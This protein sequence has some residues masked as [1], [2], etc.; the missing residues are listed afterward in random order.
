MILVYTLAI[1]GISMI[2]AS[3]GDFQYGIG[4]AFMC[5]LAYVAFNRLDKS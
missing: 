4:G 5:L 3:E 2:V 1:G